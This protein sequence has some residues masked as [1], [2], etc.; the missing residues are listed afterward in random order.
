MRLRIFLS[1]TVCV[2]LM[3]SA[4]FAQQTAKIT[5]SNTAYLQYLPQGY[6]TNSNL[7]PVVIS[8]HGIK[9]KG[10]T[11]T[12]PTDLLASVQRVANVGL[13]KYVK[14]GKQYPFILISPQLKTS[15]GGWPAAYVM[16]VINYVKKTLRVDPRRIYIT[17]LSL[18]GFGA[19]T[20]LAAYPEVFAGAIPICAGG[21][22]LSK[23][24]AVAGQNVPVWGFHGDKDYIVSYTVTTK[25]V[26]AINACTPKPSPLAKATLFPGMGHVIWDKVYNETNALDWMLSHTNGTTTSTPVTTTNNPPTVNAGSDVVEYLPTNA[27][28]C[29]GTASD[30]D[31]TV[32]SYV[33]SQ[34]SGPSTATLE[35]RY[36][37]SLKA[38][39]LKAGTYTFRLKA[40]D[41]KGAYGNDDVKV[42]INSTTTTTNTSSAP[43]VSAG[44]DKTLLVPSTTYTYIQGKASDP[45]GIASYLWTKVSGPGISVAW[46]TTSRIRVTNFVAGTYVFRLTVKDSK[47][48]TSSDEMILYVKSSSTASRTTTTTTTST[49]ST[50]SGNYAPVAS[51]GADKSLRLPTNTIKLYGSAKDSDGKIVSYQWTQYSGPTRLAISYSRYATCQVHYLKQGTYVMRLTVKDNEGAV[52]TDDVA[53]RVSDGTVSVVPLDSS[54]E[55]AGAVEG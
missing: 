33:W 55:R 50:S 45:D 18:G 49:S 4:A 31:G 26:N 20:T 54:L 37:K 36:T 53:V 32:A 39:N 30:P 16:D 25:M 22:A 15:H 41:D 52:D 1:L 23:A 47:G 7:Y 19:W 12:N 27:A 29:N 28:I 21:N 34:V 24:C 40:T 44:S 48:N 17:G 8:L 14:F 38:S 51:A 6:N 9:E 10:T 42:V 43:T 13:P 3:S 2:T 35:N 5:P 11:S 46:A